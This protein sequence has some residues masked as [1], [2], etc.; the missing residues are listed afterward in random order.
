MQR[1]MVV[2]PVRTLH[3][4]VALESNLD[5]VCNETHER[6]EI[7]VGVGRL[8]DL[9]L[10]KGIQLAAAKLLNVQKVPIRIVVRHHQWEKF[11]KEVYAMA[12][13]KKLYQPPS[14]PDLSDM[15]SEHACEDRFD[16][17]RRNISVQP[18]KL[19]DMGA[20]LG[21]FCH[22]FE[23]MGFECYAVENH[24]RHL[25]FLTRLRRAENRR[26]RIIQ[27]SILDWRGIRELTF[28]VTLALNIFHHFLE[29]KASYLQLTSLLR[30]LKTREMFFEPAAVQ[31]KSAY[32]NFSEEE[33][34]EFVLLNSRLKHAKMLGVSAGRPLYKLY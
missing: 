10:S 3:P 6:D 21:F 13:E 27:D 32:R 23:E 18:G 19:L 2:E 9:L 12:I 29:R 16:M 14:H 5:S 25:Y 15:P 31:T 34:V 20:N 28:D 22:K 11:R 1:E 26:F 30:D 4:D 33:F 7:E 24:P 17:I 8:G